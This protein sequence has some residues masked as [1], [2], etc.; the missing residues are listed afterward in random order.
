MK[1][2]LLQSAVMMG[3]ALLWLTPL[4]FA[5]W[6]AFHAFG[7]V[8]HFRLTAPLTL[9]NFVRAWQAAPF[10]IYLINTV[11][12]VVLVLVVQLVTSALAA[13][14]FAHYKFRGKNIAFAFIMVQLLIIP[15]VLV[16]ENYRT[17]AKLGLINHLIAIGLPYFA[18]A[19]G[20]FLLRQAFL[21]VPKELHEV[22]SLEGAGP[23]DMLW[24]VYLPLA[25]PTPLCQRR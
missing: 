22:A 7:D 10:G 8:T 13:F 23:L 5:F 1:A 12:M 3:L 25:R 14:A 16:A 11:L 15:N 21:S 20:I 24:R 9:A 17:M 19:F 2:K 6:A 4:L 18:S